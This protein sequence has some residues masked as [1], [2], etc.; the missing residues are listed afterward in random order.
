MV[1]LLS[2][3]MCIQNLGLYSLT[4][5]LTHALHTLVFITNQLI[6]FIRKRGLTADIR[7]SQTV[8]LAPSGGLCW[9]SRAGVKVVRIRGIYFERHMGAG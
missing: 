3:D 2:L 5:S 4:K 6:L 1:H 9:S 7:G 8:G